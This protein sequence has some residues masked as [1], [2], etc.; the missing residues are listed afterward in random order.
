MATVRT[1]LITGIE[2]RQVR[3]RHPG[4]IPGDHNRQAQAID[5]YDSERRPFRTPEA[6]IAHPDEI[7]AYYMRIETDGG[8]DGLYGP[9]DRADGELAITTFG[10]M[11]LGQD[12]FA[13]TQL[14]DKMER[15]NRHSRHGLLK[16]A[17][18]A[19]DN[20]L[21]DLKGRA[22]GAPVWQILG[23]G[24]RPRIP[25]YASMLGTPLDEATI[26]E[27]SAAVQKEGYSGQKW[28]FEHGPGSGPAGLEA[29]VRLVEIL[30]ES[31]GP[32]EPLMFDAFHSWDL[33]FARA[34][35][36]R[37]KEHHPTWLEEVF[38]PNRHAAFVELHRSTGVPLATGE[39][40]YDRQEAVDLMTN[41]T[42]VT[43]QCDPE[44]CGGVTELTRICV[45]AETFG[46]PVIP[47]G[48]GV[49]AALHV[50]A[51]QSP[52]VCPKCEYLM[53]I[54]PTRHHFERNPP[55][56]IGGAFPLP[57]GPGFGIELDKS[58]IT[59]IEVIARVGE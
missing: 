23:G 59:N 30:R 17:I 13:T 3:G 7:I 14:W 47:H 36:E 42:L 27:R 20:T 21:W 33:P 48:H 6:N 12:A 40:I 16:M 35:A 32:N 10:K 31:V 45:V 25:A 55:I 49:H 34:W 8:I 29:S 43:L 52:E 1:L 56:P 24:A 44:W 41:G 15:V 11:L 18:S 46:V 51:S 50:V 39:H 4:V 53:R 58:K 19:V 57:T 9:I 22:Y 38:L 37:V 26:R 28:F 5:V 2:L 54:M